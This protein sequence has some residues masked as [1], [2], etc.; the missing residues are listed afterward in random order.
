MTWPRSTSSFFNPR[1]KTPTL[2]PAWLRPKFL[3][4][5]DAGHDGLL[6]S[7]S[8]RRFPLLVHLDLPR[9]TRPVTT[10]PRPSI[11]KI[12]RSAS[13]T[14]YRFRGPARECNHP[15]L[16]EVQY[17]LRI[18]IVGRLRFQGF[19]GRTA[20]DRGRCRPA[21]LILLQ[22]FADFGFN[23]IDEF[24]IVH[25][26]HLV[27]KDDDGRHADLAGQKDV[28]AGLRHRAVRGRNDQDR[29]VHLGGAGDH[30]L[31]V[32][33]VAGS[34]DVRVVA[35]FR[36][37]FGVVQRNRNAARLFFRRI[38]DLIDVPPPSWP[39]PSYKGCA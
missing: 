34:I 17:R 35:F 33:G 5:F 28:L 3:E 30:V 1:S 16:H 26:I 13:G 11:E 27:Q 14:A 38:I 39:N 18:R 22:K 36:L 21:K 4:H 9:S 2:S 32:I 6:R 10:V 7:A 24:R 12:L 19:Q 8:I 23:Q 37:V 29:S 31:D 20:D 15:G 25:H